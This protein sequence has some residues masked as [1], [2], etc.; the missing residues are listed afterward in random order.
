MSGTSISDVTKARLLLVALCLA[1]GLT[2]PAMRIALVDLPPFTMRA[3]SSGIGAISLIVLARLAGR[4][5]GVPAASKWLDIVVVAFFNV[6][7][8]GLCTAFAQVMA[9]TG[10]VAILRLHHADLGDAAWRACSCTS[11]SRRCA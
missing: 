7:V 10:R 8:F 6:I 11:C 5:V 1:W 9:Y 4:P 2:W 3:M